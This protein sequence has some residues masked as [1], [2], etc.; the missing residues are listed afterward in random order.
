MLA[1]FN[2]FT[3]L[4]RMPSRQEAGLARHEPT[5]DDREIACCAGQGKDPA[6]VARLL[7]LPVMGDLGVFEG[8]K[9]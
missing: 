6:A 3:E 4:A 5:S 2:D 8:T 7:K 9:P 1:L